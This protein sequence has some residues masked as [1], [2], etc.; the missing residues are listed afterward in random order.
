MVMMDNI[1]LQK[2]KIGS[3]RNIINSFRD[4][5]YMFWKSKDNIMNITMAPYLEITD[6]S[7]TFKNVYKA[8]TDN[9]CVIC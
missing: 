6:N 9:I 7:G 5:R 4:V 8:S 3:D 1:I 2:Y